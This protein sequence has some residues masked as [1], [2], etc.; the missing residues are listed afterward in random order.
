M[1]ASK[2]G[3]FMLLFGL[4]FFKVNASIDN[5]PQDSILLK[6]V[7]IHS[8]R[9][10]NFT[11]GNKV[12]ALD[13]MHIHELPQGSLSDLLQRHSTVFMKTYGL[14]SLATT[15]FRGAG[16]SHT[17]VL[18]NGF[19]LQ[20]PMNG[21]LDFALIP[22]WFLDDVSIQFGGSGALYGSGAVGGTV[23]LHNTP[24]FDS[25][26]GITYQT[27]LGS[28]GSQQYALKA[29]YGTK[30]F[31]TTIKSYH[32]SADNDFPFVNTAEFGSPVI[33]QPNA[34]VSAYG[35]MVQNAIKLSRG[36]HLQF[37]VWVQDNDR[38][39]PPSMT[40]RRS[41]QSQQDQSYRVT[42]EWQKAS[43]KSH[44]FVRTAYFET[45][46]H[47]NNPGINQKSYNKSWS[48]ISEAEIK[49]QLGLGFELN[50]GINFTYAEAYADGY[51]RYVSQ[52]RV[53]N[54]TSLKHTTANHRLVSV[55]S[56]R[57]ELVDSVF[58]PVVPALGVEYILGWDI[59]LKGNIARNYRIPTFNDLYWLGAGARGNPD[60]RPES[61]WSQDLG[62][63][64][65]KS[66]RGFGLE[67]SANLF[68]SRMDD[69]INWIERDRVWMPENI[70]HVWSRGYEY[71]IDLKYSVGGWL[72]N[73]GG[74]YSYTRSTREKR[75]TENDLRKQLMYVPL[76]N[77]V[78]NAAVMYKGFRMFYNHSHT[79]QRYTNTDNSKFLPA[80]R[81]ANLSFGKAL[82][83]KKISLDTSL[84]INNLW[85]ESY[86]AIAFQAMPG[87]NFHLNLSISFNQ[88]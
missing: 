12:I 59:M 37:N 17:A 55:L 78:G 29:S 48:S 79:G 71:T 19:N 88:K 45:H 13:S 85:D 69:W 8:N 87:R 18:W 40:M 58:T 43:A 30:R 21:Q 83:F 51:G 11:S 36:Q 67:A 33:R 41:Q 42:A 56:L 25:G 2:V 60:L 38:Q 32:Y 65:Q 39:I 70:F 81:V 73:L 66:F 74:T 46:L 6:E 64:Y 50:T 47:F 68:S 4:V 77:G 76:H 53:A 52:G 75:A 34:G 23:H 72:F 15:S 80:F 22:A 14:G 9:L 86:Q 10:Q 3:M 28:F 63:K 35:I 5:Q 49:H 27:G 20:S 26:L 7:V 62:L 61:G 1:M 54:F 84:M 24:V 31:F 16:A 44:L 82:R 57:N